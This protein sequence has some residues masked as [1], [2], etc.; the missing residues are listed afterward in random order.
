M[1]TSLKIPFDCAVFLPLLQEYHLNLYYCYNEEYYQGD[2]KLVSGINILKSLDDIYKNVKGEITVGYNLLK[3]GI[4]YK[5]VNLAEYDELL[6]SAT[7]RIECTRLKFCKSPIT[8][9]QIS[10]VALVINFLGNIEEPNSEYIVC[11]LSSY[12]KTGPYKLDARKV[13]MDELNKVIAAYPHYKVEIP[14]NSYLR[15]LKVNDKY[16]LDSEWS[17][18]RVKECKG[19]LEHCKNQES[20][21]REYAKTKFNKVFSIISQTLKEYSLH[22]LIKQLD[23]VKKSIDA[24]KVR[25]TKEANSQKKTLTFQF[26]KL[27]SIVDSISK[28]K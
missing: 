19:T 13:E 28:E 17:E 7:D 6:A 24:I 3:N 18:H 14:K 22:D 1:T 12:L 26:E 16:V 11:E 27:Y 20:I 2:V 21:I 9:V 5:Q 10:K 4:V 15:F 8:V 23:E 25:D